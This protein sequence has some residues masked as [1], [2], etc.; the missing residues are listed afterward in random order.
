MASPETRTTGF[1]PPQHAKRRPSIA[2]MGGLVICQ[3]SEGKKIYHFCPVPKWRVGLDDVVVALVGGDKRIER[4]AV[5]VVV[6][7]L[8]QVLPNVERG[9]LIR[10]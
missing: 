6:Y 7:E 2:T 9:A 8:I 3:A 10:S 1:G 4:H 5:E